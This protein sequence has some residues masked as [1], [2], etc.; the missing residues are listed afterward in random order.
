MSPTYAHDTGIGYTRR[1]GRFG[2]SL[3]SPVSSDHQLA[4]LLQ[5]GV[6]LEEVTAL[7]EAKE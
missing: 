6:V 7:M 4:R 2:M 3:Q 5:I 1:G